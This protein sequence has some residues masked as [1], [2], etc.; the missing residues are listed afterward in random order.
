[1][2]STEDLSAVP[3]HHKQKF[4]PRPKREWREARILVVVRKLCM[5]EFED[6]EKYYSIGMEPRR[7]WAFWKVA[8][9]VSQTNIRLIN[10]CVS[11]QCVVFSWSTINYYSLKI[12]FCFLLPPFL[13]FLWWWW[14]NLWCQWQLADRLLL[15]CRWWLFCELRWE[16]YSRRLFCR[17]PF[18]FSTRRQQRCHRIIVLYIKRK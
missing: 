2:R 5:A 6:L 13:S 12:A 1:M 9:E 10:L 16:C 8:I 18:S 7:Q 11:C 15:F 4:K 14:K 3:R 17:R